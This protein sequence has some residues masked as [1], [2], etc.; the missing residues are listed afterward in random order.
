MAVGFPIYLLGCLLFGFYD[1]R[2]E[3]ALPPVAFVIV[4]LIYL[5]GLR[6]IETQLTSWLA[7]RSSLREEDAEA[8]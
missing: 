4:A 2:L 3:Q 8:D 5:L 1:T 6:H 7:A